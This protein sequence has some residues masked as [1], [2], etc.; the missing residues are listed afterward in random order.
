[1]GHPLLVAL[2][3]KAR[4]AIKDLADGRDLAVSKDRAAA[5][6]I[7]ATGREAA[8]PFPPAAFNIVCGLSANSLSLILF[9]HAGSRAAIDAIVAR[10]CI[11]WLKVVLRLVDEIPR[12]MI[13]AKRVQRRKPVVQGGIGTGIDALTSVWFGPQQ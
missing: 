6:A 9:L 2:S 3:L 10:A 1:M 4:M 12:T 8:K 5:I 7:A 13:S 11:A